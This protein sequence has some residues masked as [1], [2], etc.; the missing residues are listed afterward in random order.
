MPVL[1]VTKA[2]AFEVVCI[3]TEKI[4]RV[5][6]VRPDRFWMKKWSGHSWL[7]K[8]GPAEPILATKSGPV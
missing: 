1:Y 6:T 2:V 4:V 5:K 7:T 8:N 3:A